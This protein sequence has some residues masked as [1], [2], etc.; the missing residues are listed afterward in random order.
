MAN[1]DNEAGCEC[2][3]D[4]LPWVDFAAGSGGRAI[5]ARDDADV[6]DRPGGGL[7]TGAVAGTSSD[8][9]WAARVGFFWRAALRTAGRETKSGGEVEGGVGRLRELGMGGAVRVVRG[10]CW[11]C[12]N[13]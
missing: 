1:S 6:D 5:W 10:R 2:G 7:V 13:C 3:V 8:D 9:G 11:G 4:V 12:C